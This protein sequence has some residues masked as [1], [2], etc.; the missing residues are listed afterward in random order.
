VGVGQGRPGGHALELWA[1]A[2]TTNEKAVANGLIEKWDAVVFEP[3]PGGPTG[4]I[5]VYGTREQVNAY[6]ESDDFSNQLMRSQVLLDGVGLRRFVTGGALMDEF[7]QY[8][9]LVESL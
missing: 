1:D 5:R 2:V 6:I 4:V 7:A 3:A 8:A 9:Q